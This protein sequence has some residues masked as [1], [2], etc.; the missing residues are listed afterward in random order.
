MIVITCP[1]VKNLPCEE[2]R[3]G[4]FYLKSLWELDI[5]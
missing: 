5:A 2:G 4:D 1:F 3:E